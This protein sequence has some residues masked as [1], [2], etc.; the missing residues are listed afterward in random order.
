MECHKCRHR[1]DVEAGR[2]ANVEFAQ[3]P[4]GKCEL[5]DGDSF[6]IEYNDE[7]QDR[8]TLA[9]PAPQP[10]PVVTDVHFPEELDAEGERRVPV[11]T[12]LDLVAMLLKLPPRTRDVVCWRYAGYRYADIAR[13]QHVTTTAVEL[14]HR[15]ALKRYPLLRCLFPSKAGRQRSRK[16]HVVA[17]VGGRK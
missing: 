6:A 1:V 12:L 7:F 13:V 10:E 3:T 5:K 4:C 8:G 15:N 14:R 11:S 2:Y 17:G 9:R 16:R